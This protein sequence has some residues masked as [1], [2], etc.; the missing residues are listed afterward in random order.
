LTLC[1]AIKYEH[2]NHDV[3]GT[4]AFK[5]ELEESDLVIPVD[6]VAFDRRGLP[7]G[8]KGLAQT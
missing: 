5:C 8:R 1:D 6:H 4:I 2:T 7:T 3:Y